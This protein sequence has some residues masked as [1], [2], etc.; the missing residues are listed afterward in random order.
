[1][2]DK[3]FTFFQYLGTAFGTTGTTATVL[4]TI[5]GIINAASLV[6]GVKGFLQAS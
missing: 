4:R 6:V 1:M 2:L 5:T 3:I